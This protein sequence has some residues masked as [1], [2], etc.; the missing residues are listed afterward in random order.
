MKKMKDKGGAEGE[1]TGASELK[2]WP[3]YIQVSRQ[4]CRFVKFLCFY[5]SKYCFTI[6]FTIENN[7]KLSSV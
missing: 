1:K 3:S 5:I 2:P 7:I 4:C 6:L